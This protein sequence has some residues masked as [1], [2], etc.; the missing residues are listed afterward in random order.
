MSKSFAL[1]DVRHYE[2]VGVVEGSSEWA[3][4]YDRTVD[5]RLDLALLNCL[6]GIPWGKLDATVELGCGTGRT[7][8]LRDREDTS[9]WGIDRTSAMVERAAA[10]HIYAELILADIT[11]TSLPSAHFDLVIS[12]LV[13]RHIFN[14]DA[15]YAEVDRLLKPKRLFILVDYHPFLLLNGIPTHFDRATGDSI[16]IENA[17]HLFGDCMLSSNQKNWTMLDMRE[18]VVDAR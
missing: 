12:T 13:K 15:L 2:T 17:V 14:L 1:Y 7:G 18:K 3:S 8:Q 5:S 6:D 4:N 16:A 11:Y 10:K 9:I